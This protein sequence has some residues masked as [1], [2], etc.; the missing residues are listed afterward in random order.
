[1]KPI[2]GSEAFLEAALEIF[3][4]KSVQ[5]NVERLC[6]IVIKEI[7]NPMEL[8]WKVEENI[9]LAACF[10]D[11]PR[12]AFIME[13]EGH[14]S[15]QNQEHRVWAMLWMHEIYDEALLWKDEYE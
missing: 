1:M 13:T 4:H 5:G 7:S 11:S 2:R 9:L 6:C 3:E 10:N 8:Y 15:E 12:D 14:T